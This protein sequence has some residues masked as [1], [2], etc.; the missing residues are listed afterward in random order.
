MRVLKAVGG[1]FAGFTL[2]AMAGDFELAM[3]GGM[4]VAVAVYTVSE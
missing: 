2:M 3:F 1:L 4:A